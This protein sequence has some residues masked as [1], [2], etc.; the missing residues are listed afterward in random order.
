V[1]LG[2]IEQTIVSSDRP[3]VPIHGSLHSHQWLLSND[4]L[5]LVDFDRAAMGHA[6]LDIATF[7]AEWDYEPGTLSRVVKQSFM[8]AISGADES[9][10]NFYRAHKHVSK[11]FKATKASDGAAARIKCR[12]NLENAWRI[13]S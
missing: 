13:I 4:G 2:E 10:I 3:M 5:A 1:D 12:R 11:A 8:A 7:L 6:E 9:L